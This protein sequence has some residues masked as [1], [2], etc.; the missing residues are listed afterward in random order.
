MNAIGL[1]GVM[2]FFAGSAF[3]VF[4]TLIFA[5]KDK[6]VIFPLIMVAISFF[7]G[8]IMMI[9]GDVI[10][11]HPDYSYVEQ[12]AKNENADKKSDTKEIQEKEKSVDEQEKVEEKEEPKEEKYDSKSNNIFHVGDIVSTKALKIT[13]ISAGE[14][15]SDNQ[16]LQP[17]DGCVYWE[18]K[19]KFENISDTDQSMSSM[20][21]WE[22]YA[23]NSKVDQTW[24]GDNSGLD[25]TLSAGR[26]SE[27]TVYF[28]VPKNS[29]NIELEFRSDFWKTD[30]I[31]FVGK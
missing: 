3:F 28:E 24:I 14:Y 7:V 21:N 29:K 25:A 15:T 31:I 20:V 2:L 16:F 11:I 9:S 4:L 30:R 17:K 13:Y 19:F 10:S 18:F 12:V 5:I 22:C 27:G 26:Q 6:S 8:L 23:D 1:V